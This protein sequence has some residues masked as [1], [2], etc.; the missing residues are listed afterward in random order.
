MHRLAPDATLWWTRRC[1]STGGWTK[2]TERSPRLR[3]KWP[4]MTRKSRL[5]RQQCSSKKRRMK[6]KAEDDGCP[7]GLRA[8]RSS[9]IIGL[10]S[11]RE[12]PI[13]HN[14]QT[15]DGGEMLK[16]QRQPNALAINSMEDPSANW[17]KREGGGGG[18]EQQKKQCDMH[19][20]SAFKSST[21]A[22]G[23]RGAKSG[24]C[25]GSAVV[26]S[27]IRQEMTS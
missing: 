26:L 11:Q 5:T 14:G 4:P 27:N 7:S 19:S 1:V 22:I 3:Q 20:R 15:E 13:E 17:Q 24:R 18:G 25:T 23:E 12:N 8:S 10:L 9:T 21:V 16:G 2:G 6:E